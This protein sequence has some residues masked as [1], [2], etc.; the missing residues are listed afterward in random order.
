MRALVAYG[1]KM[2]GTEGLAGMVGRSLEKRAWV[3]DVRPAGEVATTEGYD[4]VV[5][6]G[7]LYAAR[8]HR[9]AARF[10][11]RHRRSLRSA[12]VWFFSSGPLDDT[13]TLEEIPPVRQVRK[14][15]DLV[16]ARVHTTFGGR[17]TEEPPGFMA[18]AMA[19]KLTGDWRDEAA[20]DRWVAQHLDTLHDSPGRLQCL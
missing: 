5:V 4:L 6:G 13:A 7:A 1:S 9:D 17:L 2:G 11:R 19:K 20:V 3:T 8:W 18:R 12:Y 14:L 15:M 16:G 10:V